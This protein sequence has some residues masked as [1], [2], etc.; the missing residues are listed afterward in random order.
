MKN[1]TII[2]ALALMLSMSSFAQDTTKTVVPKVH[3][4]VTN[5]IGINATDLMKQVLSLSSNNFALLPYDL[6]YK[7][8]FKNCA[9]RIGAG[10]SIANS[11]ESSTSTSVT[12]GTTTPVQPAPD[13]IVPTINNSTTF[14]Y[15]AGW[16]YRFHLSERFMAYTGVDFIGQCGSTFSQ[17]CEMNNDLPYGYNYNKE[18]DKLTTIN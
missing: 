3:Y 11:Q 10:I 4:P 6:T 16:E 12:T 1:T 7:L 17:Q 15:R 5:E 14:Y 13:E 18:T 8:I 9:I 2:L